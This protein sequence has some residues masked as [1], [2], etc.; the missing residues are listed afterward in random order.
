MPTLR[1][2]A[3]H[4]R[5]LLGLG[6]IATGPA[7]DDAERVDALEARI[8]E[9]ERRTTDTAKAIEPLA[10]VPNA[11]EHQ[12]RELALMRDG[13]DAMTARI[14]ELDAAIATLA[15]K[16]DMA[17]P[18][19]TQ[20]HAPELAGADTE[21][22]PVGIAECDAYLR[23]YVACIRDEMPAASRP[24]MLEAMARTA[25]AWRDAATGPARTAL[26]ATCTDAD[27]AS[28]EALTSMGCVW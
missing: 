21:P 4:R 10:D 9:L 6:V 20:K 13:Q 28:R 3:H 19:A 14:A 18:I 8:A 22:V 12:Q 1:W 2:P 7:C 25:E 11:L 27:A 17:E 15:A 23:K 5:L 16:P 24:A 26:A